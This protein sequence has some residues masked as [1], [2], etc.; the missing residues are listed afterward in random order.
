MSRAKAGIGGRLTAVHELPLLAM[1]PWPPQMPT[2]VFWLAL[3]QSLR[4]FCGTLLVGTVQHGPTAE[5]FC[6]DAM[7]ARAEAA[8]MRVA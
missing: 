5:L 6:A 4:V 1:A 3:H 2:Q 7:P 8:T